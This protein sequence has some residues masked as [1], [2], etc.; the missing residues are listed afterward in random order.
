V[1][2][3]E[4]PLDLNNSVILSLKIASIFCFSF[5]QDKLVVSCTGRR[6]CCLTGLSVGVAEATSLML[7]DNVSVS[8]SKSWVGFAV[9]T[10]SV[11][12]AFLKLRGV[13]VS[14]QCVS[15]IDSKEDL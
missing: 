5:E 12:W 13:N 1:L 4:S 15:E 2:P 10:G 6:K 9:G 11:V 7:F 8:G 3:L 14:M